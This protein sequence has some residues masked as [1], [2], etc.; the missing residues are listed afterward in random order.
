VAIWSDVRP[1]PLGAG[2]T[3]TWK[4]SSKSHFEFP[5]PSGPPQPFDAN[6]LRTIPMAGPYYIASYAPSHGVVLKRNPNYGGSR[7][8]SRAEIDL[9]VNVS[10][11]HAV[12]QVQAGTA[13]Y[14]TV[15]TAAQAPSLAARYGLGSRAAAVCASAEM[16]G[17]AIKLRWCWG[18]HG[19]VWPSGRR[20]LFPAHHTTLRRSEAWLSRR[21]LPET[22]ARLQIDYSG[23]TS[24]L[25]KMPIYRQKSWR[26][27]QDSNLRPTA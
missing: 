11:D 5:Q 23:P 26:P 19:S 17:P 24:R 7:P 14:S 9:A 8:H 20:A 22:V 3:C 13:D 12:P 25:Q 2:T 10:P 27:R 21:P 4:L 1:T 6:G 16:Q 15:V 18:T